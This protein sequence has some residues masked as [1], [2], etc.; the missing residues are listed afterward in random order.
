[1]GDLGSVSSFSFSFDFFIFENVESR[2]DLNIKTEFVFSTFILS[3]QS[4]PRVYV[5]RP[6]SNIC[7]ICCIEHPVLDSYPLT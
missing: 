3:D 4:G 6:F 1:M 5:F 2:V 7:D